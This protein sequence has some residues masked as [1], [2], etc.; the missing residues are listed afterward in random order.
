[1]TDPVARRASSPPLHIQRFI[2]NNMHSPSTLAFPSKSTRSLT[3]RPSSRQSQPSGAALE[4]HAAKQETVVEREM[5]TGLL[6]E[7]KWHNRGPSRRVL[8]AREEKRRMFVNQAERYMGVPYRE[9][10][11]PGTVSPLLN[12]STCFFVLCIRCN[13]LHTLGHRSELH[14]LTRAV[15][16]RSGAIYGRMDCT[17]IAVALCESA[18]SICVRSSVSW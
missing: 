5:L 1:M 17:L 9:G 12:L 15:V 10:S 13:F 16:A 8:L 14:L 3:H 2:V 4:A 18:W 11:T 7:R 6:T